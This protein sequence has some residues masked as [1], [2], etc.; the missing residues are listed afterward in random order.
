MDQISWILIIIVL[1][2]WWIAQC[3]QKEGLSRSCYHPLCGE[4]CRQGYI[5]TDPLGEGPCPYKCKP[6]QKINSCLCC[7]THHGPR[8][9]KEGTC[10]Q[11]CRKYCDGSGSCEL[12]CSTYVDGR[13]TSGC[14]NLRSSFGSVPPYHCIRSRTSHDRPCMKKDE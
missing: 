9:P 7:D 5:L 14:K 11:H 2:V 10:T 8:F 12:H 13:L 6:N 4:T 3:G 1:L